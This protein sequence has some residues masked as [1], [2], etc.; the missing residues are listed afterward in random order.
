MFIF[1]C[2]RQNLFAGDELCV[3]ELHKRLLRDEREVNLAH[4]LQLVSKALRL[5]YLLGLVGE[6]LRQRLE[7]ELVQLLKLICG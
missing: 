1:H 5:C 7:A 3:E 4:H 2:L 6:E